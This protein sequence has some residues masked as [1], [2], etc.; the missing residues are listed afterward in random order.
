MKRTKKDKIDETLNPALYVLEINYYDGSP[1]QT[2]SKGDRVSATMCRLSRKHLYFK[3]RPIRNERKKKDDAVKTSEPKWLT[4]LPTAKRRKILLGFAD[5]VNELESVK[6]L[7]EEDS[8]IPNN[9]RTVMTEHQLEEEQTREVYRWVETNR[10]K[11]FTPSMFLKGVSDR[12]CLSGWLEKLGEYNKSWK[13]RYFKLMNEDRLYYYKEEAD[14][15]KKGREQGFIPLSSPPVSVKESAEF[16]STKKLWY[17]EVIT[18]KR[19]WKLRAR[20]KKEM[21]E[22]IMHLDR[23]NVENEIIDKLD[24]QIHDNQYN[25]NSHFDVRYFSVYKDPSWIVSNAQ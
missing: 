6:D 1:S 20:S 10:E 2:L 11:S 17:F 7:A 15:G 24:R 5:V 22:W 8:S 12:K 13:R 23:S 16:Q 21:E 18:P 19:V 4:R 25:V 9:L 3:V 14:A